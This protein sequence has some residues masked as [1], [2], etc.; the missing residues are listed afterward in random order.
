MLVIHADWQHQIVLWY[1]FSHDLGDIIA[2][3]DGRDALIEECRRSA[4]ELK[5]YLCDSD[6]EENLRQPAGMKAATQ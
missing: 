3:I 4:P 6:F 1:L 5:A 2:V